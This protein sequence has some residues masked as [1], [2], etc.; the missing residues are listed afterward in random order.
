M[1]TACYLVVVFC[2]CFFVV[3]FFCNDSAVMFVSD[4]NNC[5]SERRYAADQI[6]V[7]IHPG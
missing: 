4:S 1:V 5:S 7:F 3:V 2:F 6:S